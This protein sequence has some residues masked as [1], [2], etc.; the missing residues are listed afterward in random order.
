MH[1]KKIK[2]KNKNRNK[3]EQTNAKQICFNNT[4]V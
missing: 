1:K 2:T 3:R 4:A